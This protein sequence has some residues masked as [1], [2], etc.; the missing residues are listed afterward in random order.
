[1]KPK[2]ELHRKTIE[3]NNKVRP[4]TQKQ[5]DW[6]VG[7]CLDNYA[8][9]NAKELKC[10]ECGH[11]WKDE[12][13]LVASVAGCQCPK[14]ERILTVKNLYNNSAY[15]SIITA[16]KGVQVVR[17][18]WVQKNYYKNQPPYS[19]ASEVTRHF[20]YP[21]GK[22]VTVAKRVVGFS[23]CYDKWVHDSEFE[24][25]EQNTYHAQLRY[26]LGAYKTYPKRS[27]IN[28]IK[29]NGFKGNFHGLTPH[30]FFSL[31]LT[32]TMAE[33][34]LKTRQFALLMA[35]ADKHSM[36]K[37]QKYW[38]TIKI[39]IRSGYIVKHASDYFDYLN[40]LVHFGKDI[41]NAHYV[42][43]ANFMSAHDKYMEK[44]REEHRKKKLEEQ[45]KTIE[46]EQKKYIKQKQDFFGLEFKD[47]KIKVKVLE[48][49]EEFMNEG[50]RLHHCVF[51][52]SYYNKAESLILSA[53][54]DN[55]PVETV[56]V[57]LNSFEVVQCRGLHN[58][59]TKHHDQI[60]NLVNSNIPLIRKRLNKTV[61]A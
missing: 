50:D 59:P 37:I 56:E 49:V 4:I 24:I 60:V 12:A 48:S 11:L 58:K 41:R 2:T 7:N 54:I 25:R 3:L 35:S 27:I 57:S 33:T 16:I 38:P 52:G 51:T 14:C 6:G 42:C 22:V 31:I 29:R 55:K 47:K 23:H 13:F 20:I 61:S 17:M 19:W 26:D 1:M 34:L 45:R 53:R 46:A 9:R 44:K 28:E 40:D 21:E 5:L 15:Y 30:K 10:L 39:C 32:D 18:F 36:E 8:T 43:P